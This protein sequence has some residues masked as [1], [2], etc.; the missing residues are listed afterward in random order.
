MENNRFYLYEV[1]S[2]EKLQDAVFLTNLGLSPSA[3]LGVAAN[4]LQNILSAK[5]SSKIV[6]EN[7]EPMVLWHETGNLFRRWL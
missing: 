1:T 6:D 5:D 3:H 7:G 4:V 2:I